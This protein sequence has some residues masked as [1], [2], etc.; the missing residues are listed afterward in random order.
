MRNHFKPYTRLNPTNPPIIVK[1]SDPLGRLTALAQDIARR[2]NE[3]G[4]PLAGCYSAL[5]REM[6]H[7][8]SVQDRDA[9]VFAYEQYAQAQ[10]RAK[11][12]V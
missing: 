6:P 9:V 5:D 8:T 12:G 1:Q 11:R 10:G 2:A 3:Q 7:N 4:K